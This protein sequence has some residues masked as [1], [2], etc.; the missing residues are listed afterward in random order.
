MTDQ[1]TV[2]ARMPEPAG[3]APVCPVCQ[4]PF[5]GALGQDPRHAACREAW[6]RRRKAS[7]AA[8]RPATFDEPGAGSV[9]VD[10]DGDGVADKSVRQ[11]E[12]VQVR[13]YTAPDGGRWGVEMQLLEAPPP[14]Q[15]VLPTITLAEPEVAVRARRAPAS[16]AGSGGARRQV[17]VWPPWWWALVPILL[18]LGSIGSVVVLQTP[19]ARVPDP[20]LADALTQLAALRAQL[21]AAPARPAEPRPGCS[22]PGTEAASPLPPAVPAAPSAPPPLPAALVSGAF[23]WWADAS[24]HIVY[25]GKLCT[26]AMRVAANAVVAER[27][28]FAP[29]EHWSIVEPWAAAAATPAPAA[30]TP[31]GPPPGTT[32]VPDGELATLRACR[33]LLIDWQA[34]G[35]GSVNWRLTPDERLARDRALAGAGR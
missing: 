17:A 4:Q 20:Q 35:S 12:R 18:L 2:A 32:G 7:T 16:A 3:G 22:T 27:E 23:A 10:T 28:R 5:D 25:I 33:Q 29:D 30:A 34:T 9:G 1:P 13:E 21:A 26:P 31:A 11:G 8:S 15:H 14:P 6:K 19:A 24:A